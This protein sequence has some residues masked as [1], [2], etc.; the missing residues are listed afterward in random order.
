MPDAER[1]TVKAEML[2][3]AL[4][5]AV[6]GDMVVEAVKQGELY[7]F[8]H[9]ETSEQLKNRFDGMLA[10]CARWDTYRTKS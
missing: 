1:A 3:A 9:P 6:V 10:A 7:I 4:D 2:G 5:P 8:T